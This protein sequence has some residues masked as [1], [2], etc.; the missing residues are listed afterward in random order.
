MEWLSEAW[1]KL[2]FPFR[3]RQFERDLEEEMRFH[4]D[5]KGQAKREQGLPE[6]EALLAARRAFGNVALAREN[7]RSAWGWI[8]VEELV[9]DVRYAFR[10]MRRNPGATAVAVISLALA[11]GPNSTLFSVV[12]RMCLRPATVADSSRFFFL[13][14]KTDRQNIWEQPS[15][16]DYLDYRQRGAELGDFVGVRGGGEMVTANGVTAGASIALVTQNYFNVLPVRAAAGRM[17]TESDA[18]W[19]SAPPAVLSYSLWQRRFGGAVD[20]VGKTFLIGFRP[21]YVAGVAARD[22]RGPKQGLLPNDIWIPFSAAP[23]LRG[24]AR[25]VSDRS[26]HSIETLVR[27]RDGVSQ[28]QA[29]AALSGI[30]KGL[31]SEYPASNHAVAAELRPL[32]NPGIEA[33]GLVVLTLVSLVLLIAC[34]NVAG[35]LLSQGEARRREFAMRLALGAGRG[36]LIRQ[37][38]VESAVLALMASALG[39]GLAY[40]LVKALPAAIPTLPIDIDLDLHIDAVTLGYTLLL[41]LV[42][43]LAAGLYPALRTSRLK[44]SPVLKGEEPRGRAR[45]WLR[46][47]LVLAQIAVSQFLLV[48][49]CLLFRTYGEVQEMRPGFDVGRHVLYATLLPVADGAR[50]DYDA[51]RE[52]LRSVAGVRRVTTVNEPPLSGSGMGVRQVYLPGQAEPIGIT[53]NAAGAEYLTAVGAKMVRGR[54]FTGADSPASAIV[55]EEMARRL[56]GGPEG[57]MGRYFQV[58]GQERRIVGVVETGKYDTLLEGPRPYYYT[59]T[60]GARAV[61]IET[62][63]EPAVLAGAIRKG[64]G[65]AAPGMA[66]TSLVTLRQQMRMGYFLFEASGALFGVSALL[67]IFLAGVGLYG[68]AGYAVARRAKEIGIRMALG[69]RPSDVLRAVL[70]QGLIMA[71]IGTLLGMAVAVAAARV[72]SSVLYRV[73]PADPLALVAAAVTVAAVT[74]LAMRIPARRAVRTDPMKV[75]RGE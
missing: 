30:A 41:S 64:L 32:V 63:P 7:A 62:E 16:P 2:L 25:Y 33:I 48:G 35:I 68:M 22:Y 47:G 13:S 72:M 39:L 74:L 69:A 17:L 29:E 28:A 73:S 53:G 49:A 46:G 5:M 26:L 61:V 34:A 40:W 52:R 37:L 70:R 11:I 58:D 27:L 23:H 45:S 36:R 24:F 60:R 59:F 51:V 3:R 6:G 44:L 66:L 21:F 75:L 12:D 38:L 54:D 67:G 55:N 14:G 8:A 42:A 10:A 19:E 57:A 20:V 9:A 65:D 50:T 4:L 31:A 18:R 71:A 43:M 56:W 15:Y 1:R